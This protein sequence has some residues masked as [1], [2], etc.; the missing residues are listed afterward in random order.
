MPRKKR[1]FDPVGSD[2][3]VR[4]RVFCVECGASLRGKLV[5]DRCECGH[6]VTDS[7]YGD[8]LMYQEQRDLRRLNSALGLLQYTGIT[9]LALIALG[10]ISAVSSAAN[11][12]DA[13]ASIFE[14]AFTLAILTPLPATLGITLVTRKRSLAYYRARYGDA[15]FLAIV[16]GAA[17]ILLVMVVLIRDPYRKALANTLLI[18]FTGTPSLIFLMGFSRLMR[19]M[20]HRALA[21]IAFGLFVVTCVLTAVCW[22]VLLMRPFAADDDN[23]GGLV[24]TLQGISIM[25]GL[26]VGA[27]TVHMLI[28]ARRSVAAFAR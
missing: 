3:Y 9:I 22:G 2:D 27:T 28:K 17:A 6:T 15:R 8:F 5:T 4:G 16:T 7:V 1:F 13:L 26:G 11:A 12:E 23:L 25:I 21:N 24:L 10:V 19:H 20:P 18:A 14:M